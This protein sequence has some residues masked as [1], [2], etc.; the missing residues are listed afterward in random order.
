MQ[1]GLLSIQTYG[2]VAPLPNPRNIFCT[3]PRLSF[4]QH[5]PR[6]LPRH[7]CV[8]DQL[9][10]RHYL[11]LKV[12]NWPRIDAQLRQIVQRDMQ[13]NE[14]N[15][16]ERMQVI[17]QWGCTNWIFVLFCRGGVWP[18]SGSTQV[19]GGYFVGKLNCMFCV[20][21]VKSHSI[22]VFATWPVITWFTLIFWLLY[23]LNN[24]TNNNATEHSCG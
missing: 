22:V 5:M 16:K 10:A 2:T 1:L 19:C 11:T 9:D 12:E 20:A 18:C 3:R 24:P 13:T 15:A 21:A 14:R 7:S 4:R 17:M 8:I 6:A 23:H